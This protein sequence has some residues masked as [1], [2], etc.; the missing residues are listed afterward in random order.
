V[1]RYFVVH[2]K[3]NGSGHVC[4]SVEWT[5]EVCGR[6]KRSATRRRTGT[7]AASLLLERL[8]WRKYPTN[9][10]HNAKPTIN[11]IRTEPVCRS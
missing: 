10:D 4:L 6:N 5:G 1:T 8:F 11:F 2:T 7:D 9:L 3:H